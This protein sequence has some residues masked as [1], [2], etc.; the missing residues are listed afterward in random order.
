MKIF[1]GIFLVALTLYTQGT[2]IA[3]NG[4]AAEKDYDEW[5]TILSNSF[6]GSVLVEAKGEGPGDFED[7]SYSTHLQRVKDLLASTSTRPFL[8]SLEQKKWALTYLNDMLKEDLSDKYADNV[9]IA[10]IKVA[11][12]TTVSQINAMGK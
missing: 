8:Q 2:A 3:A 12:E 4:T 10:A 9:D 7:K 1:R 5:V 11:V 6:H